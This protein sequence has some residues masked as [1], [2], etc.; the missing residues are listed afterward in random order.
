MNPTHE[1]YK[2]RAYNAVERLVSD[3]S[4]TPEETLE[5]LREIRDEIDMRIDALVS[6]IEG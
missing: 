1:R 2:E 3:T 4:V 6:D 5:S